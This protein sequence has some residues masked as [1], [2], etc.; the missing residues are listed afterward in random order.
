MAAIAF[1]RRSA[2]GKGSG[3]VRSEGAQESPPFLSALSVFSV[4]VTDS[5]AYT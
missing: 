1:C 5:H 2:D 4:L 3:G